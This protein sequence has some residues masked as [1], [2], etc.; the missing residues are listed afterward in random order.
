MPTTSPEIREEALLVVLDEEQLDHYAVEHERALVAKS[1][2]RDL[3]ERKGVK[4]TLEAGEVLSR[5]QQIEILV[6]TSATHP[7]QLL[8]PAAEDPAGS[9]TGLQ[10][11][12]RPAHEVQVMAHAGECA[13]ALGCLP[14]LRA[15]QQ[16]TALVQCSVRDSTMTSSTR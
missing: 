5:V 9:A 8:G 12:E 16:P 13:G 4:Q 14:V 6:G 11:A 1:L 10:Q 2:G 7:S 15:S 3:L